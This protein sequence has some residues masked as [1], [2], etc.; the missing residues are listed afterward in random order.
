MM[1]H[2]RWWR[3]AGKVPLM[4]MGKRRAVGRLDGT[5]ARWGDVRQLVRRPVTEIQFQFLLLD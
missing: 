5:A 4:L 1:I 3:R 2:I